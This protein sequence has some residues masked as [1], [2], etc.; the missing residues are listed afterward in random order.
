MEGLKVTETRVLRLWVGGLT[1]DQGL[2]PKATRLARRPLANCVVWVG[3]QQLP[4]SPWAPATHHH[5]L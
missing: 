2:C 4:S 3:P 1:P 5:S